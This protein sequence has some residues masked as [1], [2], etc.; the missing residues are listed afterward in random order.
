M[1][2]NPIHVSA[3]IVGGIGDI[4]YGLEGFREICEFA[5]IDGDRSSIETKCYLVT[6][7]S[8]GGT[9]VRSN[10]FVDHVTNIRFNH[11]LSHLGI[12]RKKTDKDSTFMGMATSYCYTMHPQL[13]INN[14]IRERVSRKYIDSNKHTIVLH[15]FGSEFSRFFLGSQRM[16]STKE[17][18]STIWEQI[19]D[20][21]NSDYFNVYIVGG[22]NDNKII[23]TWKLGN[24]KS[25]CGKLSILESIALIMQSS[26]VVGVDS[27]A[28]TISLVSQ[29]PTVVF[30]N[31]HHDKHRD[32]TFLNPYKTQEHTSI[33]HN[34]NLIPIDQ[35]VDRTHRTIIGGIDAKN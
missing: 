23:Q 16:V 19:I 12:L 15:P 21:F 28:K 35:L 7:C 11:N 20:R 1:Y 22:A 31:D 2:N 18:M 17:L 32:E 33:I 24:A 8:E 29:L 4:I 9:L 26:A 25:L 30:V 10:P 34:A 27:F 5:S 14:E 3:S 13:H 6:H